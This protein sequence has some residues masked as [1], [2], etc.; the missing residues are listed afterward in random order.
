MENG[1]LACN[2]YSPCLNFLWITSIAGGSLHY[3]SPL[4]PSQRFNENFKI[5]SNLVLFSFA[6]STPIF[7]KILKLAFLAKKGSRRYF[8]WI[9]FTRYRKHAPFMRKCIAVLLLYLPVLSFDVHSSSLFPVL[10]F[11]KQQSWFGILLRIKRIKKRSQQGN[12]WQKQS[13]SRQA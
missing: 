12:D 11:L 9:E 10:A 2:L 4:H 7:L 8:K 13:I 3:L 5:S 6:S 1:V